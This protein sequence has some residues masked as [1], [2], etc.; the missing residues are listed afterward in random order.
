METTGLV[1]QRKAVD[2]PADAIRS[3]AV[4]AATKGLSLKKYLET[5][6]LEQANAIDTALSN[7]SPS[8]DPYFADSRN[9]ERIQHSSKQAEEGKVTT[10]HGRDELFKLLENI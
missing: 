7:P 5:I 1:I 2:I 3:L 10:V 6:I 9:I 4:A 8:G